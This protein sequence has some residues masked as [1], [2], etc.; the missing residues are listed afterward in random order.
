DVFLSPYSGPGQAGPMILDSNGALV[1]FK[2]LPSRVGATNREVE[3]YLGKPVLTW[4]EGDISVHGFG[5]G[6]GVIADSTYNV[7][8]HVHAGNGLQADLHEFRLTPRGTALI[9]A[10]DPEV[11]DLSAV[12]GAGS[13]A[14]TNGVLQ[15][16][17]I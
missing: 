16:V 17:D 3:Q 13:S 14:V 10:Y 8:G 11:C 15:E 4:W 6:Q 1:W 5:L 9:T 12:G 2:P 7:L